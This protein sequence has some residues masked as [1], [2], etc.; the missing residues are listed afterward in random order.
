MVHSQT[1][2]SY[3]ILFHK[4]TPGT[5]ADRSREAHGFLMDVHCH[6]LG[7]LR[8]SLQEP[9]YETGTLASILKSKT[10]TVLGGDA[11]L[12]YPCLHSR[13]LPNR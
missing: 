12:L 10:I 8:E 3:N 5:G 1:S 4:K 2:N 11:W 6:L 7:K 13:S 9:S